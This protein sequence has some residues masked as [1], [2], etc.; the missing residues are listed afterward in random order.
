MISYV[1]A[2]TRLASIKLQ[3]NCNT[4]ELLNLTFPAFEGMMKLEF[5]PFELCLII[6]VIHRLNFK[7]NCKQIFQFIPLNT[8]FLKIYS[9]KLKEMN[10]PFYQSIIVSINK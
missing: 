8:V 5:K 7:L 6:T 1:I 2:T 10:K 4:F 9:V 3:I